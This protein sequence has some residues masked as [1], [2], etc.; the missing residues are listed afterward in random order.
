VATFS[1]R[2]NVG[3]WPI[4]AFDGR[5]AINRDRGSMLIAVYSDGDDVRRNVHLLHFL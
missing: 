5:Q 1:I 3:F 2:T 4:S